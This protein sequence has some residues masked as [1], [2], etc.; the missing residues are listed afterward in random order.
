MK[1][2]EVHIKRLGSFVLQRDGKETI[3]KPP[4][5]P[6]KRGVWNDVAKYRSNHFHDGV[7]IREAKEGE[8]PI[9]W[10]QIK[11]DR[12][13]WICDRP[14]LTDFS[15]QEMDEMMGLVEGKEVTLNG[16]TYKF[17]SINSAEWRRYVLNRGEFK[18][19]PDLDNPMHNGAWHWRKMFAPMADRSSTT[20]AQFYGG[21]SAELR[22]FSGV[23]AASDTYGL[24]LVLLKQD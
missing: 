3:V 20:E 9:R 8:E 17:R 11:D 1:Y 6:L 13:I 14:M 23:N 24:R 18:A 12:E 5:W 7:T 4:E 16:E 19:L 10:W 22:G 15:Y 21:T 2:G